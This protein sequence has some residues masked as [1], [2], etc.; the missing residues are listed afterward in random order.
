[1]LYF[2]AMDSAEASSSL[3]CPRCDGG[4]LG[5][6]DNT[7]PKCGASRIVCQRFRLTKVLG[8]GGMGLIYEARDESDPAHGR[9]AVKTLSLGGTTDWRM[10]EL[11][12]R[13][14]HVLMGLTHPCLPKVHAF[15]QDDSG[16]FVLVRDVFDGGTL[17]E[18]IAKNDRRLSPWEVTHLLETL[19]DLLVYLQAR[20]PPVIHRDI[21]PSNV[22]F[23]TVHDD[24]PVLVDFDSVA[25]ADGRRSGVTIVGTPGY[26]APEQFAGESS[27]SSDVYSLGAT[28]LFVVTHRQ[29]DDLPRKDGR[30]DVASSLSQLDP[31]TRR[32]LTRMVETDRKKRYATA[33]EALQDLQGVGTARKSSTRQALAIGLVAWVFLC[34][35][36]F[37]VAIA[38]RRSS[39]SM[40][41]QA[42]A[43]TVPAASDKTRSCK[44]GDYLDCSDRCAKHDALSCFNLGWIYEKGTGVTK[45]YSKAA[46]VYEE[47]CTAKIAGA[48]TNLGVLY[49]KGNGVAADIGRAFTLYEQGC[50]LG[51]ALGCADLG[52]MYENGK[53]VAED[54]GRA[55]TLYTQACDRGDGHGCT[56]LGY[57]YE[58]G[59]GV[60][61]DDVRAASLYKGS[62]DKGTQARACSLLGGMTEHGKGVAMD[63]T[64][65]IALYR[66]GC[67]GGHTWGCEQ[68]TRLEAK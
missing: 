59:R 14:T 4:V 23:R 54:R 19:L 5:P 43:R 11:F 26:A 10:R 30:F 65:A 49:E 52:W 41:S 68:V 34:S 63:R 8:H 24:V 48:C 21:K 53:G 37:V 15:E 45:D 64:R 7:C 44:S 38:M 29:A 3:P 39:S 22:M 42:Q 36:T 17:E 18:R 46:A 1:V 50:N 33:K 57:L 31:A 28:M 55:L 2:S 61:E 35:M 58:N 9:V 12:E 67:D 25:A 60:T 56:N 62:C 13:S 27:P 66:K 20:V 51:Q 32:V 16:R 6:D 40:S 47:A